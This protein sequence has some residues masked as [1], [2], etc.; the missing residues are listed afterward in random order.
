MIDLFVVRHAVT[1]WNT[2]R[3]FQGLSDIPIN[4]EGRESLRRLKLPHVW[5]NAVLLSSPLSRAVETAEILTGKTPTP[6]TALIEMNW[7][8]W[9][10]RKYEDL[11]SELGQALQD[12]ED[13]GLDFRP[14]EGESPRDVAERLS[15]W[16]S[17]LSQKPDKTQS[18]A[19]FTH[20]G[21]IR[22]MM[23]IAFDWNMMGKAPAKLKRYAGHH[24]QVNSSGKLSC[25]AMNVPL[26]DRSVE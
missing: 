25:V 23:A 10:G 18:I 3:R 20:K 17:V 5:N 9:E 15:D 13:Q 12:N 19:A 24:F 21:I 6:E 22:A 8:L 16:F 11:K 7:G 1:D 14:D 2:E 4:D 26:E